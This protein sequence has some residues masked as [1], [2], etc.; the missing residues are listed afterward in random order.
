MD[1]LLNPF[2]ILNASPRDNR[3]RIMELSEE[4][5]LLADSADCTQACSDL[6][7]PRK[8]LSAEI[9][10]LPGLGPKRSSEALSVLKNSV[11]GLLRMDKPMPIARANLLAAGLSRLPAST[12][13]AVAEWILA[14]ARAFEEIEPQGLCAVINEDRIVSGFPQVTDLSM[15]EAEIQERRRYYR[16]VMKSALNNL[17]SRD[18]V[19]AVTAAVASATDSGEEQGPILIDDLVDTYEVEAQN[20]LTKE[21]GCINALVEEIQL[22]ADTEGSI[23]ALAA[24]INLLIDVVQNWDTVAQPIQVSAKSRGLDHIASHQ[25]ARQVRELAVHLFNEHGKLEFSQQ[26]TKMLQEVFLEVVEV[27]ERTVEDATALD[28]IAEHRIQQRNEVTFEA[29]VGFLFKNNLRIAPEG[30]EWRKRHWDLDSITR[31]RWGGTRHSVNGVP[32]G[33]TYNILFGTNCE[34]ASIELKDEHI[35][36]NFI[37]R[38]WKTVGV[39]LLTELLEALRDGKQ[40]RYGTTIIKD[41]GVAFERR[42]FLSGSEYFFCR[43]S[44]L[45]IGSEAGVFCISNKKDRRLA[46][47]FSY[48]NEDNIHVL[49]AA[50]RL[51]WKR[52]SDR[53]SSLLEDQ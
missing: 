46:A 32:T 33:T 26:L 4:H 35:Y 41:Q 30:I 48:Q 21:A 18:L 12:P 7:N 31:I 34:Y 49:E 28:D 16:Q 15:I 27:A 2:Y 6:V 37:E 51:L 43:W 29:D 10:W 39:R 20:F 3:R 14:L 24:K 38:L 11:A 22:D 8:R 44:E 40:Y 13:D 25:V 53:L 17:K 36:S 50:I 5:S 45:L 52:G 47:S 1:L 23:S 42:K 9:A 19:D